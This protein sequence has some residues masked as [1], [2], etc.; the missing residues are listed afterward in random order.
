MTG[1]ESKQA[2]VL[3]FAI[4]NYY[5]NMSGSS[6]TQ[7]QITQRDKI[8]ASGCIECDDNLDAK[9]LSLQNAL[10][11]ANTTTDPDEA[12]SARNTAIESAI[13]LLTA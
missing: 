11:N 12:I 4:V 8:I 7:E 10:V 5:A 1:S 9:I 3:Y 2:S 13:Q 6:I